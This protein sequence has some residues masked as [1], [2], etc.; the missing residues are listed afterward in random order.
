MSLRKFAR[1]DV[2]NPHL[3]METVAFVLPMLQKRKLQADPECQS[4]SKAQ[5]PPLA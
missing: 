1:Q 2:F 5:Y 3:L 4:L